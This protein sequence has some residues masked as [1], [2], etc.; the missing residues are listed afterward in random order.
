MAIYTISDLHLSKAVDKPM[1]VFG[2]VWENYMNKIEENWNK[3]VTREDWVLHCGDLS[4]ATYLE[5]STADFEFLARL[6]GKK[7]LCKGNHDYWWTTLNKMNKFLEAKGIKDIFFLHNNSYLCQSIGIC[8]TRGWINPG[9]PGFTKHDEKIFN[10]ELM[11]LELSLKDLKD[12]DYSEI[13]VMLHYPPFCPGKGSK[14]FLDLLKA[15]DVRRCIYGHLHGEAQKDA[16][17]GVVEGI[18]FILTSCDKLNFKPLK[19]Y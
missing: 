7:I 1:D 16:I 18:E 5:E 4:W 9:N 3:T 11:R 15:Y 6:P 12:K 10:R 19:L 14:G 8:G 17:E 2:G 13:I